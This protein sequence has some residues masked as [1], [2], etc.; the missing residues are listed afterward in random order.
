MDLL[1]TLTD[2]ANGFRISRDGSGQVAPGQVV[3]FRLIPTTTQLNVSALL[4]G[5]ISIL[6]LTKDVRFGDFQPVPAPL[7][8][9]LDLLGGMP[10]VTLTGTIAGVQGLLGQI[11]GTIPIPLQVPVS[12]TITWSVQDTPQG[13][14]LKPQGNALTLG[15]DFLAP[16]GLKAPE[17]TLAFNAPV[18]EL[19]TNMV[20]PLKSLYVHAQVVLSAQGVTTPPIDLPEV[21]LTIPALAIPTV[22]AYFDDAN[23]NAH[24]VFVMVPASSP[25]R[26]LQDLNALLNPLQNQVSALSQFANFANFLLGI[27]LLSAA[28]AAQP[29]VQFRA[30]DAERELENIVWVPG[31]TFGTDYDADDAFSS[32]IFLAAPSAVTPILQLSNKDRLKFSEEGGFEVHV[33]S[34]MYAALS[35]LSGNTESAMS[36][37]LQPASARMCI[38]AKADSFDSQASSVAFSD[39]ARCTPATPP[40]RVRPVGPPATGRTLKAKRRSR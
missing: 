39:I 14:D 13:T 36:A 21:P 5:D 37:F 38:I 40:S 33:G 34:D 16:D 2:L 9:H 10:I 19:T 26:S 8:Q 4:P 23:Y 15:N 32:L 24:S 12:V 28:L 6:W 25:L 3:A 35:Q 7:D 20:L 17:I 1:Q 22:A 30:E 29:H 27:Q 18:V 11:S 31:S